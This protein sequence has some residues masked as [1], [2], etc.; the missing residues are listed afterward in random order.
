MSAIRATINDVAARAGVSHQTVSRVMNEHPNVAPG[1]R[2]KVLRVMRELDYQPNRAARTLSSQRSATIGVVSFGLSFYGPAQMLAN[3]EQ[4]ARARGYSIAFASA[5]E[6]N[7]REIER[8]IEELRKH[9][10]DGILLIVPMQGLDLGRVREFCRGVPFA[11]IDTPAASAAPG[12]SIDQLEGGRLGADHLLSL[13]HR[14]VAC[15]SGP[16]RWHDARLRAEGW[17]ATLTEAGLTPIAAMEGDWTP[18]SG[19]ALTQELLASRVPFTGL[20]VGNDQM[21]LGALWALHERGVSVPD[22]VSVVGFDD[23]PESR[24]FHPPLTTVRQDFAALGVES[25]TALLEIIESP[26]ADSRAPR[27]LKPQLIVRASTATP[28]GTDRPGR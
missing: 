22:Q 21:A 14:R 20:L 4:A 24:F 2:E 13:G 26:A 3:V 6:L 27:V 25:L 18:A 9:F 16:H 7:E 8:A 11:L 1:T 28:P 23:I 19:F 17:Q 10:V 5:P 15:I 12:A